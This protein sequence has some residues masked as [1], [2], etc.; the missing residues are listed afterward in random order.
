MKKVL[1]INITWELIWWLITALLLYLVF[2]PI[3]SVMDY[4]FLWFNVALLVLAITNFRGGLFL[5]Q[6]RIFRK[7]VVRAIIFILNIHL[8][9]LVIARTHFILAKVEHFSI[10]YFG[11]LKEPLGL[12]EQ[13]HLMRYIVNVVEFTAVAAVLMMIF[14]NI[15]ILASYFRQT[16]IR[17][18]DL[19][20]TEQNPS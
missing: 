1:A 15:R 4:E 19:P 17:L 10:S 2:E 16:N 3:V 14:L 12:E 11:T 5:K 13:Y 18:K 8:I 20:T 6:Y 9:V 7:R